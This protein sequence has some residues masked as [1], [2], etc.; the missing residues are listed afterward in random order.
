MQKNYFFKGLGI[1]S[2]LMLFFGMGL[3]IREFSRDI[4]LFYMWLVI[5]LLG[6]LGLSVLAIR[7]IVIQK[8]INTP[9]EKDE[10]K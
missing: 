3:A 7:L 8:R 6:F 1:V 9:R 4:E 5:S 10:K 2:T